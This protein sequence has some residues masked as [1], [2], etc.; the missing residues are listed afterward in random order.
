MNGDTNA[1]PSSLVV[2]WTDVTLLQAVVMPGR[3][4]VRCRLGV[5]LMSPKLSPAIVT[6]VL[7][8]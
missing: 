1:R 8:V 4:W 2:T 5:G 3:S 7:V 6:I